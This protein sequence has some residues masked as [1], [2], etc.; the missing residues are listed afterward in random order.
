MKR[1]ERSAPQRRTFTDSRQEKRVIFNP[2]ISQRSTIE[3][4]APS[5]YDDEQNEIEETAMRERFYHPVQM[6]IGNNSTHR[7]LDR[8]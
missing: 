1:H 3:Q 5:I 2:Y 6:Y 8:R 4:Q 7:Q